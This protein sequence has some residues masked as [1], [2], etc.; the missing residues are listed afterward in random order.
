MGSRVQS[1]PVHSEHAEALA[2]SYAAVSENP[3]A[4]ASAETSVIDISNKPRLFKVRGTE[5]HS[6]V[7]LSLRR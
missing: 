7:N 5:A 4:A 3:G 2:G 6:D 1:I